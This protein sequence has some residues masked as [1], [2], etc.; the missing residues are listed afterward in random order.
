MNRNRFGIFAVLSIASL[1]AG[2]VHAEQ[3][4]GTLS[5]V[6]G[7]VQVEHAGVTATAA[8]GS[9]VAAGDTVLVGPGSEA[10]LDTADGGVF[11]MGADTHFKVVQYAYNAAG[12][13]AAVYRVDE[14]T[15]HSTT[16][17]IG[18]HPGDNFLM[19]TPTGEV[20]PHGTDYQVHQGAEGMT[21]SVFSGFVTI[22]NANGV[23]T[24]K[25]GEIAYSGNHS[26]SFQI[27]AIIDTQPGAFPPVIIYASAS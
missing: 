17:A 6:R 25:A 14:G 2:A 26:S 27:G 23:V 9:T 22:S 4:A 5:A 8:V 3:G 10:R 13:S 12:P 7:T 11:S 19:S 20:R 21:V 16:G 18:K 24:V 1:A 15:V